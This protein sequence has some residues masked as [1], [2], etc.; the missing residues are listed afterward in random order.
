MSSATKTS[1]E[2]APSVIVDLADALIA[3]IRTYESCAVAFSGGVDSAVVL[4][5]A[6]RALGAK[7]VALTGIGAAVSQQDLDAVE[8]VIEVIGVRSVRIATD[9]ID[10]ENYLR[11]DAMRCFHC[12]S[13]LYRAMQEWIRSNQ[14]QVIASGTNY[15]DLSDYRPG[16]KA[17]AEFGVKMPLVDLKLGK[18][19]IRAL[20]E[21]WKLPN[22]ARLASPCLASRLAYG[23]QVTLERLQK[24][25]AAEDWLREQGFD[26]VRVRLH[27]DDLVRIELAPEKLFLLSESSLRKA[28][29]EQFQAIGFKYITLDLAGRQ[30]GSLNR[31]LPIVLNRF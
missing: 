5:A 16:L 14:F 9:E 18:G 30:S 31:A 23:Q 19:H 20:A 26:D 29:V 24:I 22:A 11:N 10:D 15:D 4:M 25:E 27:A 8:A 6:H 17:A 21:Y 13:H 1:N 12:K 2:F 7:A 3:S 28:L